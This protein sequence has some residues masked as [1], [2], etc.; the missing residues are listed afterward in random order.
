MGVGWRW[1]FWLET[2][3]VCLSRLLPGISNLGQCGVGGILSL[4]FM[5]ESYAPVLLARKAARL[6]KETGSKMR[7]KHDTGKTL[8]QAIKAAI[9]RPAK[10]LLVSPIVL[11]LALYM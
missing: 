1:T 4:L 7:S 3:I 9:I 10:L 11:L 5:R 6:E 2:I 8:T